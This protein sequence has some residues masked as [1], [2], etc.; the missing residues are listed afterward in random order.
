MGTLRR[1]VVKIGA[2]VDDLQKGLAQ[3]QSLV[4]GFAS[5]LTP[6][7]GAIKTA[8][9]GGAVAGVA[10]AA[11][12]FAAL[13]AGALDISRQIQAGQGLIQGALGVTAAE[14]EQ[15]QQVSTDAF[16]NG[17]YGSV[18]QATEAVIEARR[19]LS[20]LISGSE[21]QSVVENAGRLQDA[22]QIKPDESL[23]AVRTLME[24]FGL[25]SQQAFDFIASGFQNG[26][27]NSGDFLDSIGEYSNQFSEGGSTAAQFFS[28]LQT[29]LAGGNL[30][31]DKIS[32]AFKEFRIRSME[33]GTSTGNLIVDF[34]RARSALLAMED[35]VQRNALGVKMFGT[36]WED[37]GESAILSINTQQTGLQQMAGATEAVNAQY[38]T[39]GQVIQGV[40]RQTLIALSPVTTE[41]L[42]L[43]NEAGPY[44][45]AFF[46]QAKPIIEEFAATMSEIL[47][48]AA[49]SIGESIVRIGAALGIVSDEATGTDVLLAALKGTLDLIV[50]TVQLVTVGFYLLA[51]AVQSASAF[52]QDGIAGW[53]R[54]GDAM[55]GAS[56]YLFGGESTPSTPAPAS[57][58]AVQTNDAGQSMDRLEQLMAEMVALQASQQSPQVQVSVDGRQIADVI[59]PRVSEIAGAN[60]SR[61]F[62]LGG[63]TR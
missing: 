27:N 55:S 59:A 19:Q 7:G 39:L 22:F 45:Q 16:G 2:N 63:A 9:A 8:L 3:G 40:W 18:S 50:T 42:R 6:L 53:Q 57:A 33:A 56:D 11:T 51:D 52:V 44:V 46:H 12:A 29:G 47:F 62:R 36:M 24:E 25:S 54:F 26:L 37:L 49:Q 30:G 20:G 35:P 4:N 10:A 21:M 41:L 38:N 5:K 28:T 60:L 61:R 15:L 13:G 14:A 32:D 58:P 23:S 43:A 31:T 1:L 34:E 48:P 17:F